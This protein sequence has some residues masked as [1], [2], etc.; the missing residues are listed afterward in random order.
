MTTDAVLAKVLQDYAAQ[1]PEELSLWKDGIVTVLDQT[2]A[3]G[4]WKGDLNG[5]SGI[6]PANV[7][8]HRIDHQKD[9]IG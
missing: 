1:D 7:S 8:N 2:I 6:F 5:N 9:Y 3:E 4:W